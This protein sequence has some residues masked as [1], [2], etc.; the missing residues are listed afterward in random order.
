MKRLLHAHSLAALLLLAGACTEVDKV[1]GDSLIPPYQ[2]LG[3]QTLDA[4]SFISLRNIPLDSLSTGSF[5]YATLGRLDDPHL[6]KSTAGF[7]AQL[8][9]YAYTPT[10]ETG[11]TGFDS[12]YLL[13]SFSGTYG[14]DNKNEPMNIEVYAL[15]GDISID[16][17]YFGTPALAES[18]ADMSTDLVVKG[19]AVAFDSTYAFIKLSNTLLSKLWHL[20]SRDSFLAYLHGLYVKVDNGEGGCVK[21]VDLVNT[22]TTASASAL[23]AY[24]HYRDSITGLDSVQ[25]FSFDAY[26]GAPRFNVFGHD[27]KALEQPSG[28]ILYM[29]GMVGVAIE[30]TVDRSAVE[31]WT[32]TG[33]QKK[34]YAVSRAE[35]VLHVQDTT[36]AL[37]LD[38]YATQ[39]YC[40][41]P[42]TG[43]STLGKYTGTLDTYATSG[44]V[45]TTFD[46]TLNR[47][48]MQYSLN[49]TH[50]FNDI[51]QG[52]EEPLYLIP[53]TYTTEA[54]SVLIN[55]LGR[56]PQLKLTYTEIK[57]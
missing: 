27:Y 10:F 49:I 20:E 15:T 21:Y 55:N 53:Y 18:I 36:D 46:G 41:M 38:K 57:K 7:V 30:M 40:L 45:S 42:T 47:S 43:T 23:L 51:V 3:V 25:L 1:A 5:S 2:Q 9:P 31:A 11:V 52:T 17:A 22:S 24:Y 48:T 16:S 54:R 12:V 39:L 50:Y 13:L 56:K 19:Q 8:L 4:S 35:L 28:D 6:G 14:A 33:D 32:G 26:S 37:L 29:Q 44:G 34:E